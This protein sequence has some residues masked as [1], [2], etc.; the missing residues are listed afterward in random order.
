MRQL[1][2]LLSHTPESSHPL[3]QIWQLF[4][5]GKYA[6]LVRIL[7]LTFI[8]S[9]GALATAVLCLCMATIV[10]ASLIWFW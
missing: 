7:L 1:S 9:S 3:P 4:R 10:F 5:T 8:E 6:V 2:P